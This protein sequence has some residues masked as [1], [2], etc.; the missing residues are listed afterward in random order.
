MIEVIINGKTH[1][2]TEGCT[3]LSLM[4]EKGIAPEKTVAML[5][6]L[7]IKP[8]EYVSAVLKNGDKIELMFFVGG[9]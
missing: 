2:L 6:E 9:G 8:P 3:L 4:E 5:N 7:I 1:T